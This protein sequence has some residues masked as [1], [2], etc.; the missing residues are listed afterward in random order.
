MNWED[1]KNEPTEDLIELI[2]SKEQADYVELAQAAFAAFT[3][4]FQDQVVDKCRKLGRSWGYDRETSD[5]LAER[6]FE[7]FYRYPFRFKKSECRDLPV[8]EC[9]KC[10]LFVT[11]QHCF[12][13]YKNEYTQ[14]ISPY[15]GSES[16]VVEFPALDHLQLEAGS[17]EEIREMQSV[18][19]SALATLTPNHKKIYLTYKMYEKAGFKLPRHLLEKLRKETELS[20]STIRVYKKEAIKTVEEHLKKHGSK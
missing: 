16:V 12:C 3:F 7:K 19:E 2:K 8:N 1:L 13:D 14:D 11:A 10:Y 4:R 9:V 5:M 17:I 20:Q 15:D 6:T 18:I